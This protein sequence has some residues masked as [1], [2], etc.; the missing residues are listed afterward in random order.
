VPSVTLPPLPLGL[1]FAL[2]AV[3]TSAVLRDSTLAVALAVIGAFLIVWA[4]A[5]DRLKAVDA[6]K[7]DLFAATKERVAAKI[8]ADAGLSNALRAN[9]RTGQTAPAI[10]AAK[11][12]EELADV[13]VGVLDRPPPRLTTDYLLDVEREL[14]LRGYTGRQGRRA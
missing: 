10:R 13:I 14:T 5:G 6:T 7:I 8:D 4:Y 1:V 11:T 3:A 2:L 12:P 9:T